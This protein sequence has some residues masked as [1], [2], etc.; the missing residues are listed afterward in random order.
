M[1]PFFATVRSKLGRLN[2]K[3][4]DGFNAILE[5]SKAHVT[6]HRAY[7]LATAWHETAMT[8][9]PIREYGSHKY[10][11]KYDTARLAE[12]LG[13]TPED[14]DDGQLFAGRGFVQI[15]GRD[16]YRRFG[17]ENTPDDALKLD[18]ATNIL[19]KGMYEGLFTGKGLNDYLTTAHGNIETF[20]KAR[21]IINGTDKDRQIAQY[22]LIFQEALDGVA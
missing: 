12:R 2:Q 16:N 20:T 1:A 8:M 7:M 5:A 6:S 22:A 19:V 14:D 13:N 4:V 10:L 11:D 9:Q 3:Q 17:I 21:R 18:V 15:T